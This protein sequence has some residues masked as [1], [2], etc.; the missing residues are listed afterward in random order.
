[1]MDGHGTRHPQPTHAIFLD[2]G[3]ENTTTTITTGTN[4]RAHIAMS[5]GD[6]LSCLSRQR[7]QR[8]TTKKYQ[9][10]RQSTSRTTRVPVVLLRKETSRRRD[11]RSNGDTGMTS[12]K[13]TGVIIAHLRREP[14]IEMFVVLS[15]VRRNILWTG[16][17]FHE[18]RTT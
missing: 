16:H 12:G 9:G 15:R 11:N 3:N 5:M 8:R 17:E 7:R 6:R 1:M 13:I 18:A 14:T 4:A 10:E 2:D